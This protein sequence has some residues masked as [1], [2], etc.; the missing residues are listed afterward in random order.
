MDMGTYFTPKDPAEYGPDL[1]NVRRSAERSAK[2]KKRELFGVWFG[3][4]KDYLQAQ[5]FRIGMRFVDM[6]DKTGALRQE[7]NEMR[8]HFIRTVF[9]FVV[10]DEEKKGNDPGT[11]ALIA[12]G[13]QGAGSAIFK[14]T[15]P[16]M[17]A[18]GNKTSAEENKVQRKILARI[19]GILNKIGL[20]I[21]NCGVQTVNTLRAELRAGKK[22]GFWFNQFLAGDEKLYRDFR[23]GLQRSLR[24][25]H[26]KA[27]LLQRSEVFTEDVQ[28]LE[29]ERSFDVIEG[30][31]GIMD[32][33]FIWTLY[34]CSKRRLPTGN[35]NEVFTELA[36][37][38]FITEEESETLASNLEFLLRYKE[39]AGMSAGGNLDTAKT[40]FHQII[41]N[42]GFATPADF[43]N[44]FYRRIM[45][46]YTIL[47][48]VIDTL[49][50]EHNFTELTG[51][52]PQL[53]PALETDQAV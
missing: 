16:L 1:A 29:E 11:Y 22:H 33:L 4:M 12:G 23:K 25:A 7:H 53:Q 9:A 43:K 46:N 14:G 18:A 39:E 2:Y 17:I 37:A 31:G 44:E 27:Q 51:K 5:L 20:D 35:I 32:I 24:K 19:C 30:P 38:E 28:L 36:D 42:L 49:T 48:R 26:L 47:L 21:D 40:Y 34:S 13:I 8:A 15:V 41:E 6:L 52:L 10:E 45:Q 50:Q 3:K